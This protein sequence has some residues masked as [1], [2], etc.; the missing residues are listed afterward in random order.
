MNTQSIVNKFGTANLVKHIGNWYDCFIFSISYEARSDVIWRQLLVDLKQSQKPVLS[1]YNENH[2]YIEEFLSKA[3]NGL[4]GC[5]HTPIGLISNRPLASFDI[6]KNTIN[7]ILNKPSAL[8]KNDQAKPLKIL[9]DIT[10]FTRETL[11]MLFLILK[12]YLPKGSVIRCLYVEADYVEDAGEEYEHTEKNRSIDVDHEWLAKGI[13][14]VR[15]IVGYRGEVSLLAKKHLIILPGRE[16]TRTCNIIDRV[17]PDKITI[18]RTENEEGRSG[19]EIFG[20]YARAREWIISYCT[21][22]LSEKNI[23]INSFVFS[24]KDPWL[25]MRNLIA[26]AQDGENIMVS[27]MNTKIA[28]IGVCMAALLQKNIQL[29]YAAPLLYNRINYPPAGKVIRMFDIPTSLE[30][31]SVLVDKGG[32]GPDAIC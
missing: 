1:F 8:S 28:T 32:S 31:S 18:G 6:I 27:C 13:D 15:F 5:A 9:L 3:K 30:F 19:V 7:K 25:T 11:A 21:H 29:I 26:K 2:D 14:D 10:C 17:M 12:E 20:K 23:D 24:Y 4:E 16:E 22:L